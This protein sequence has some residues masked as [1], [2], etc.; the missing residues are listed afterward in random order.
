MVRELSCPSAVASNLKVPGPLTEP[1]SS[2]SPG[3]ISTGIDSPVIA[4]VFTHDRPSTTTPSVAIRSPA[5]T[6]RV[7]RS[8]TSVAGI[9]SSP[10]GRETRAV[11]GI[12]DSSARRP[13]WARSM[14][15]S[16]SVSAMENKNANAAASATW[17]SRTAP[18]AAM[19][20]S[21][22]TPRRA[23][24]RAVMRRR[25]APGTKVQAPATRPREWAISASV[26]FPVHSRTRPVTHSRP[27]ATGRAKARSRHHGA[28][29]S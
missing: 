13:F 16:S 15:L 14:A 21:S 17:P 25:S 29:C 20:I 22:P 10:V 19:V 1:A 28:S 18:V 24:P 12:S 27:D 9:T 4:E 5:P 26:S 6:M 11:S 2:W 3:P 8:R 7:S 23:R